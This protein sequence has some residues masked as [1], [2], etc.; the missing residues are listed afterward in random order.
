MNQMPGTVSHLFNPKLRMM[1]QTPGTISKLT[2]EREFMYISQFRSIMVYHLYG[3][4]S[5][6]G[7]PSLFSCVV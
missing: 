3:S 6:Q 5:D 4:N 2:S 7:R 1:A